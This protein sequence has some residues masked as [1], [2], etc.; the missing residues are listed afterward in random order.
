MWTQESKRE[1]GKVQDGKTT[2]EYMDAEGLHAFLK[3]GERA[4]H[5]VLQKFVYPKDGRNLV[6]RASW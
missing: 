3:S 6:I 1:G 5:G 2:I 4:S